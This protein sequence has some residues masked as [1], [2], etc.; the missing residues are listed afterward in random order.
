MT[1]TE[2]ATWFRFGYFLNFVRHGLCKSTDQ[3]MPLL[4]MAFVD[5]N[6]RKFRGVSTFLLALT[7]A[8]AFYASNAIALT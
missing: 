5:Q 2:L 1:F 7:V 8:A 4:H 3:E 6:L